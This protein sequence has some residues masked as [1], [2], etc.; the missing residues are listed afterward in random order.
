MIINI[1]DIN[2]VSISTLIEK[3]F[4]QVNS[5]I[6][7]MKILSLLGIPIHNQKTST[8]EKQI[9]S[10]IKTI[11]KELSLQGVIE[12]KAT[13]HETLGIKEIAYKKL[14]IK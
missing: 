5:N 7:P 14:P 6:T 10:K 2:L 11:L 13:T 4:N 3:N 1:N 9:R 12:L 8:Q